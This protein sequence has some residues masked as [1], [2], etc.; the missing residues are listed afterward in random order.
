MARYTANDLI[1][2]DQ[3]IRD[4]SE[5]TRTEWLRVSYE[6]FRSKEERLAF[7]EANT[8]ASQRFAELLDKKTEI[9]EALANAVQTP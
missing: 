7:L 6:G 8:K 5:A 1:L 4:H 9:K 3:E 2:I